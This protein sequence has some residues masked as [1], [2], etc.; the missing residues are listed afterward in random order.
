MP[1]LS[2]RSSLTTALL[3]GATAL[4]ACSSFE[5][6][7]GGPDGPDGLLQLAAEVPGVEA[8][9]SAMGPDANIILDD[10]ENRLQIDQADIVLEQVEFRPQGGGECVDGSSADDGDACFEVVVNPD[11]LPLPLQEGIVQAG[12]VAADSGS[13]DGL[14]F[15]VHVAESGDTNVL[16]QR[17]SMVGASVRVTGAFNGVAFEE[18]VLLAPSGTV[19]LTSPS[20]ALVRPG[21]ATAMTLTVDVASWFRNPDGSLID[22]GTVADDDSLTAVVHDRILSSFSLRSGI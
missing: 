7:I 3:V 14:E 13:Y 20:P 4:A 16:D 2:L 9:S 17:P 11:V 12:D 21:E 22:P 10:G 19:E 5:A 18:P 15:N 6:R 8:P 1:T